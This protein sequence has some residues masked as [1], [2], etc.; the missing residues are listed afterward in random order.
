MRQPDPNDSNTTNQ[1]EVH[2]DK[3]DPTHSDHIVTTFM[4]AE[5]K[6]DKQLDAYASIGNSVTPGKTKKGK[7]I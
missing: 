7:V 5:K 4:Q 3:D 1:K 6:F 2:F